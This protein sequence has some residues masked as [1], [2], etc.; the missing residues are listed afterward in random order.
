MKLISG[1]TNGK[2]C[3][4][5]RFDEILKSYEGKSIVIEVKKDEGKRSS[6]QNRGLWR[7]NEMVSKEIGDTPEGFH[8][9]MCGELYGW[10]KTKS[11]RDMP[12]KTTSGMT[13]SEFSHHIMLY[14]IKVLE[15][16]NIDLPPFSYDELDLP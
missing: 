16:F 14:R 3:L 6:D 7:W 12:N 1:V 10:H 13:T 8:Y 11:G 2:L 5:D 15:L 4:Q 9:D